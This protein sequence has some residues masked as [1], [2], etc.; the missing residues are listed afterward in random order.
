MRPL[1][2]V[3]A[4]QNAHHIPNFRIRLRRTYAEIHETCGECEIGGI[5]Y[6]RKMI[7]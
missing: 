1:V 7:E 4:A 5:I 6:F 3:I 2:P